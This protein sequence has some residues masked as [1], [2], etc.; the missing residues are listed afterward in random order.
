MNANK[1]SGD[2]KSLGIILIVILFIVIVGVIISFC[3]YNRKKETFNGN[4]CVMDPN[5]NDPNYL[6]ERYF[7][8]DNT[9]KL[10]SSDPVKVTRGVVQSALLTPDEMNQYFG[11]AKKKSQ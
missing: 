3:C 9:D 6:N 10:I 1:M 5:F 2:T 8:Y 7:H 11:S 4:G